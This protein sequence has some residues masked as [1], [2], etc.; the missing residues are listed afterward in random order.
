MDWRANMRKF[1][2]ILLFLSLSILIFF[3]G[4]S[5]ALNKGDVVIM[6][7]KN[8]ETNLD[9]TITLSNSSNA[10]KNS[11]VNISNQVNGLNNYYIRPQ[12][13]AILN[14]PID[15]KWLDFD[16]LDGLL[17]I[18]TDTNIDNKPTGFSDK[19]SIYDIDGQ[20]LLKTVSN[21]NASYSSIT[22]FN[23]NIFLY[24]NKSGELSEFSSDLILQKKYALEKGLNCSKMLFSKEGWLLVLQST[25]DH[26][27][28][29]VF[30]N[31][32]KLIYKLN[33]DYLFEKLSVS[34]KDIVKSDIRDFTFYDNNRIIISIVPKRICLFD[35][36][37]KIIEKIKD[38]DAEEY[39]TSFDSNILYATPSTLYDLSNKIINKPGRLDRTFV[40]DNSFWNAS[41]GSI[42]NWKIS[43][44]E[45][46]SNGLLSV[47]Q[48]LIV[49]DKFIY[50]LD[51]PIENVHS[52]S[53]II[54]LNK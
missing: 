44:L 54:V 10:A 8:P 24:D 16:V 28:I 14:I 47:H 27:D 11:N 50:I 40:N 30:D 33:I 12:S 7:N 46:P 38:F 41:Q 15:Q 43:P 42:D 3:T 13:K 20:Q 23:N 1:N 53:Q 39:I 4:C 25:S 2:N 52:E 6:P 19:I 51:Y 26:N 18:I 17:Y 21:P 31:K 45:L 9:T 37:N 35:F 48:K 36:K 29:L 5:K 22:A 49:R 34:A 32:F